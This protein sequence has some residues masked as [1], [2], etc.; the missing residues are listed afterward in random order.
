LLVDDLK[1]NTW[2]YLASKKITDEN[3]ELIKTFIKSIQSA[4]EEIKKN[5]EE[6][7]EM[8]SQLTGL[9]KDITLTA[10]KHQN[11]GATYISPEVVK[12]QQKAV[13]TFYDLKLIPKLVK[14]EEVTWTP[15]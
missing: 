8:I 2:Y 4:D 6:F 15:K 10:A 11:Y 12:E 5:P 1:P 3:P 7:A 9:P 13:Q 14:V